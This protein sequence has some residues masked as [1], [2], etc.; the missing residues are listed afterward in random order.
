MIATRIIKMRLAS[1]EI[2]Q[3]DWNS[4]IKAA[5]GMSQSELTRAADDAAKRAVLAERDIIT[6]DDLGEAI[7]ERKAPTR[8]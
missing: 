3:I 5:A 6:Q 7:A 8:E 1:F 2:Q 4:A